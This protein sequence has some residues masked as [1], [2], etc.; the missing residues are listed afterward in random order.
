MRGDGTCDNVLEVLRKDYRD[1]SKVLGTIMMDLINDCIHIS[2]G[3]GA[4]DE[5]P[6]AT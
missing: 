3:K 5:A 1:V 4:M 2:G 6:D